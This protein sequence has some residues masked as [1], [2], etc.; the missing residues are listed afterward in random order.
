MTN[1]NGTTSTQAK[2][3]AAKQGELWSAHPKDWAEIQERTEVPLYLA[4]FDAARVG[5]GTR[6]LDA[7]C[8][9]GT[10]ALFAAQRGAVVSG[11]DAAPG[12]I[13]VARVRV[14]EG[15]FRVGD[16]EELPYLDASFDVGFACNSL[17]YAADPRAAVRE[18]A[19][20]T[21][22]GGAVVAGMWGR[23][24][25][26]DF[27]VAMG[28]VRA[29]MPKT[30]PPTFDL[31]RPGALEEA[32]E[33]AGL[34]VSGGGEVPGPFVYLDEETLWRSQ[35]G[36]GPFV[37]AVRAL[38]EEKVRRTLADASE[39]FRDAKT[40]AYRFHNTFRFVIARRASPRTA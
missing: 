14:P 22:P 5:L 30:P 9:G 26:Q 37:S 17:Q 31:A 23:P 1:A 15:D 8:G 40:G 11:L 13:D 19:R 21:K 27:H 32:F 29:L 24:E 38:G 18:L 12:L 2:G 10:A 36:S 6:F 16:L 33:A 25:D 34:R 4:A 28:A 7:G 3:S 20:V 39:R 35:R